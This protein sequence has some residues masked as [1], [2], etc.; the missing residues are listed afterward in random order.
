L[1][2]QVQGVFAE[3]ERT[4]IMERARRG[5]LHGARRG[6]VSVLSG[7]PYGYRYL[8]AEAAGGA[9]QYQVV[10]EQAAVVRQVFAWVAHERCSINEVC[11]RLKRQGVPS[12]TGRPSWN[13]SM[14]AAMLNNPAYKGAAAFGRRRVCPRLPRLRPPRGSGPQ[15]RH[16]RS[17]CRAERDQWIEIPVPGI[18]SEGEFE[19][20]GEQLAENRRRHRRHA[21]GARYLLQGLLVCKQ[22]GYAYSSRTSI[23]RGKSRAYYGCTRA[24]GDALGE[25]KR[26]ENRT[27]RT[28]RLE[29]AV[30]EDVC[31]L[32]RDPD[33][34][35]QEYRR[36]SNRQRDLGWDEGEQRDRLLGAVK[37]GI[38]RLVDA[39]ADGLLEREEFEPRLRRARERLARLEQEQQAHAEKASREADLRV[40]LGCLAEFSKQVRES[41]ASADW[42]LRREVIRALVKEVKV[43]LEEVQI[44]YRV[45]PSPFD[46][47]PGRGRLQDCPKRFAQVSPNQAEYH[48]C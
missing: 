39:Y 43:D 13:R 18:V 16:D 17:V 37:R 3:Y 15:P 22:C 23:S 21:A 41:L 48:G 32:L 27:I 24:R 34:V 36:R 29:A 1:L 42:S 19:A 46:P 35:E 25:G 31:L 28:E 38:G 44:V 33:R 12:P 5:K 4:K 6:S 2:L 20:V 14:I 26:C 9:A 8:S 45:S 7:A 10:L 11:R 47:A 40:A 30:W